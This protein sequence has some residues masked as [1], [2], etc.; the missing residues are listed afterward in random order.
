MA[1]ILLAAN[2]AQTVLAA[3]ISA[4]ATSITVNSG[5]GSLFPTPTSG[6]SFFKLTLIDA[7]TGQLNEIV[8]VTAR[9]GDTMTIVR[10]QE[11]TTSRAWSAND[12][13]ANMLTSG[14]LGFFAQLES[15][16]FTGIPLVPT[17]PAGTKTT[18]AASTAFVM[19]ASSGTVGASLN[20]R[21]S[22]S[23]A[24]VSGTFTADS[25]VVADALNG[26]LYRLSSVNKTI[27]LTTTGAGGMDT[28]SAP[29][30]GFV[31]LYVI[32]NPTTD[33]S[34]MLAVNATSSL[35]AE[36]YGGANM[37]SGY[38][39]SSLVAVIPTNSSSQM[40][41]GLLTGRTFSFVSVSPMSTTT[42]TS[43]WTLANIASTVPKNTKQIKGTFN[44]SAQTGQ[45]VTVCGVAGSSTGI[46]SFFGGSVV[47]SQLQYVL[48]LVSSQS[49][50]YQAQV[51]GGT[52][53]AT[54]AVGAYTI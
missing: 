30:S 29:A 28:G 18:Q 7:A 17:A 40:I 6:V 43:G 35:V 11:G 27:N 42:A 31:G 8:H 45:S 36:I 53:G 26:N 48:D 21:M 4:S 33:T 46:G 15:P 47:S 1:L 2:N 5:T 37:P 54:L 38:T 12:I 24:A 32:Y 3:G 10:G 52:I 39:A 14:T 49:V 16:S 20:A 50:Y 41:I 13:A 23:S 44:V 9:V 19:Q 51:S 22:L 34:A 25:L